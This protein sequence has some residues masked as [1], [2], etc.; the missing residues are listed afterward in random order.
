MATL[1]Q[2]RPSD[3]RGVARAEAKPARRASEAKSTRR[4]T[5]PFRGRRD[6][7][8][9]N[10]PERKSQT[11]RQRRAK[12]RCCGW[13]GKALSGTGRVTAGRRAPSEAAPPRRA[14]P[15]SRRRQTNPFRAGAERS[16]I[17]GRETNSHDPRKGRRL[18]CERR[19]EL[20]AFPRTRLH[21]AELQEAV[22]VKLDFMGQNLARKPRGLS[23]ES[24]SRRAPSEAKPQARRNEATTPV[25]NEANRAAPNEAK[26]RRR[27]TKP[28]A[29]RRTKPR[30]PGS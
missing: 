1:W 3:T 21:R 27:R 15:N 2:F 24:I 19:S 26:S 16:Q 6:E 8:K 9:P 17:A 30:L 10:V 13:R 29:P 5:N 11:R 25:P 20:A 4:E 18:P 12:P 28:I 7:A 14:K 22:R 23:K